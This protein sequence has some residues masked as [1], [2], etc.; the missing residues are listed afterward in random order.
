M[1]VHVLNCSKRIILFINPASIYIVFFSS[2]QLLFQ[3][4][5]S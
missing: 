2:I 3:Q 5:K 1:T 4:G